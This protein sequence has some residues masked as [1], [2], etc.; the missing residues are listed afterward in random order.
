MPFLHQPSIELEP[1]RCFLCGR[2]WACENT[3]QHRS[4]TCPFCAA[5]KIKAAEERV[6]KIN[7]SNISLR[8]AI[9]R[10]KGG[11]PS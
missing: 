6:A 1:T 11:K 3:F 4:P 7:R 2:Y 8:G 10:I 5:D 9:R